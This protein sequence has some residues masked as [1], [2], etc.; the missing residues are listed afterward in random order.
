LHLESLEARDCPS[1]D[2]LVAPIATGDAA[3]SDTALVLVANPGLSLNLSVVPGPRGTA[4]VSGQVSGSSQT[5]GLTVILV[6]VVSGS[7]T[8]GADG[9]FTYTGRASGPGSI[10]AFVTDDAGDMVTSSTNLTANPPTVVNFQAINNGNNN[11]T[12]T[13][14]VQGPNATGLV[15]MLAGIPSLDGNNASATVQPNG[16]FSYTVTLRPGESGGV[17]A[18]C[19]DWWGQGSNEATA[20]VVG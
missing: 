14:Q 8:T 19:L 10:K 15:V 17:T 2:P 13:G 6:G 9:T 7:V 12:F 3:S 16:S 5:G 4:T 18:D 11:W 20:Y 1:A